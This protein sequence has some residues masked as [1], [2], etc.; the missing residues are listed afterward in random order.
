MKGKIILKLT[1][2]SRIHGVRFVSGLASS[3]TKLKNASRRL[4]YSV[5]TTAVPAVLF[6]LVVGVI[7]PAIAQAEHRRQN[8]QH[9]F[10][11]EGMSNATEL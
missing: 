9:N 6:G 10:Y 5:C 1:Q 3:D 4:T 11:F 8:A 7:F 2:I